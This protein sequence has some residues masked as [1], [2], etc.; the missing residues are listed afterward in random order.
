MF[1]DIE[2]RY[3]FLNRLLSLR[4]DV[5]WRRFAVGR[6]RFPRTR[7][8]LD[9]AT[10]TADLVVEALRIHRGIAAVGL[11]FVPGMIDSAC[12]KADDAGCSGRVRLVLGDALVLPFAGGSFD[13]AAVAFGIRNMPDRLGALRE[14]ARVVIPGGQVMV[15]EMHLPEVPVFRQVY[16]FYLC[17]V[18]P[19][20]AGTVS[21]KPEAYRYLA[22]SIVAFP[23][24]R[25]FSDMMR[26]AGLE[27]VECHPLTLG[28]TCLHVGR[29][30]A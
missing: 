11:D 22:E 19:R 1:G 14:M 25:T 3:D 12:R 20:L 4:R 30:P 27:E 26:T 23:P 6:M 28:V 10:G 21:G 7:L 16:R 24:P 9:V 5:A 18:L 2:G 8:L 13:V 29:K 17:R 15:L